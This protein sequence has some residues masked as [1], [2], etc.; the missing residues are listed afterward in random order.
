MSNPFIWSV[1]RL[2]P[3]P[4]TPTAHYTPSCEEAL[5]ASQAHKQF[6]KFYFFC[7]ILLMI[8]GCEMIVKWE[9]D[10]GHLTTCH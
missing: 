1:V 9:A 8:S 2:Q 10:E 3:H 4:D 6:R 7:D 5:L